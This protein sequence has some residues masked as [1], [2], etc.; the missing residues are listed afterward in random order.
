MFAT[1]AMKTAKELAAVLILVSAVLL[2][3]G[4]AHG[5]DAALAAEDP[6]QTKTLD[7]G[8]ISRWLQTRFSAAELAALRKED[9]RV[10]ARHCG[11]YDTPEPHFPYSVLLVLTP[12]GDLVARA[13]ARENA[14]SITP[15]AVRYGHRYCELE[16]EANCYGSFAHACE[17]TDFRYGPYLAE[18]FPDCK[19]GYAAPGL[20][21]VGDGPGVHR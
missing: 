3:S 20:R 15:L 12:K 1:S 13:E 2:P 7:I 19:P 4:E 10:E 9:L 16:S 14:V 6:E 5:R 18:F 8:G 21:P 17:F 11:C